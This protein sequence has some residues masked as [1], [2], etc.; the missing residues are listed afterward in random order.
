MSDSPFTIGML[1]GW[2]VFGSVYLDRFLQYV[3]NGVR[4]AALDRGCN[5]M[6][7]CGVSR[8]PGMRSLHTAWPTSAP[9]C[10]YIPVGEWNT[11]GLIVAAPLRSEERS[12]YIRRIVEEG[13]PV[14]FIG[15]GEGGPSI[16][17]DNEGGVRQAIEHLVKHGHRRIAFIAGDPLDHGDST[18]RLQAYRNS[19]EEFEADSDPR[20][21]AYGYHYREGGRKAME[22]ILTAG[23]GFTAVVA[24][25]DVSAFGAMETL[26]SAGRRIPTDVAV[27]G[28]D[29][30]PTAAG[31][32]PPLTSVHYPLFDA[33][34]QAVHT[35]LALIQNPGEKHPDEI[36]IPAWLAIRESCGCSP[37]YQEEHLELRPVDSQTLSTVD[38]VS[39]L[40][41]ETLSPNISGLS[42][43][44]LAIHCRAL[45]GAFL[46]SVEGEEPNEFYRALQDVLA[47]VESSEDHVDI[48][49][50]AISLL[51]MR[52]VPMIRPDH[53][54]FAESLLHQARM[55]ISDGAERQW[56][57]RRISAS[58]MSHQIGW[59]ATRMF[60][61]GSEKEILEIFS[62]HLADIGIPF[63]QVAFFQPRKNDPIGGLSFYSNLPAGSGDSKDKE[64][65][66]LCCETKDFPTPEIL[67]DRMPYA[68]ALLPL[69]FQDEPMG[70]AVFDA[71][72]LDPL[73]TITR[74]LAAALKTQQLHLQVEELSLIDQ[75]TGVQN[76]RFFELFLQR[77]L[78]RCRRYRRGLT[79]MMINLD[80]WQKYTENY[81]LA[82]SREAL[83]TVARCITACVRRGSDVVCRYT[84][85]TF[86]I[87]LPETDL[88]GAREIAASMRARIE[89]QE[90]FQGFFDIGIGIAV[91][92]PDSSCDDS[93]IL[94]SSA[95]RALYQAKSSGRNRTEA[96]RLASPPPPKPETPPDEKVERP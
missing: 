58:D 36:R 73:A 50:M 54:P 49:Q 94:L 69:V 86:A 64:P 13:F 42:R 3:I 78:E 19:I 52:T 85:D 45:V 61:A 67:P 82:I 25:N 70:F 60:S 16:I 68:L 84:D 21:V 90:G 55:T 80:G 24:S 29:D 56:L 66:A 23:I 12:Q 43:E 2:P 46:H 33:G 6:V 4:A 75:F 34:V 28:F 91:S 44:D 31:Q 1:P 17:M 74:Q 59:M 63:A 40:L 32:V 95:D 26:R 5:L 83:H 22:Q 9:D 15:S 47:A 37:S 62:E 10:D 79:L 92:T 18:F 39:H 48:W 96:V 14:V 71:A 89:S 88:E 41:Q 65:R 53:V 38:T 30:Q 72:N 11:D 87:L 20:L 76:R 77:E 27:I 51:R 8:T 7:A 81:G 35:L 93:E 57:R